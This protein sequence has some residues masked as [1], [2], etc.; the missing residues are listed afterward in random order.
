MGWRMMSLTHGL[1]QP[2]APSDRVGDT[3]VAV[4]AVFGCLSIVLA[5]YLLSWTVRSSA[6]PWLDG[7]LIDGFEVIAAALCLAR[8]VR[9]GPGRAV[10]LTLG[11]AVLSW[12]IGDLVL[13]AESI[14]GNL[15]PTP[16]WADFF[17]VGFYPLAYVGVAGFLC[18]QVRRLSTPNWLD[19]AVAAAGAAAVCAAFEFHR[20]LHATGGHRAA[21]VTA[22][23]YPIGDLLLFSLVAGGSAVMSGQRKAPWILI[24]TAMAVNVAGDTANLFSAS[25]PMHLDAA[26]DATS[27][28]TS[29]LLL[30]M[31]VWCRP[32]PSNPL[33]TQ[34]PAG[35]VI[36]GICGG[37]AL[38]VL[39]V[40]NLDAMSRA[41]VYLATATLLLVG[42]RLVLSMRAMR[43][44]SQERRRQSVTDELTGL[45]NRRH[46]LAVL[47]A[48][49]A[50]TA[51]TVEPRSLAFLFVDLDHFKEIND[52][53]GH[54]A[55]DT[56]LQHV[57]D[58]L[59][60]CMRETDLLVRLGG[61]EFVVLLVDSDA[62]YATTV[63]Q[64]VTASLTEPMVIDAVR[65]RIG[66]SI[67][68]AFAPDDATNSAG[69]LW[70]ADVAM[71]RA[72]STG[73]PYAL[74]NKDVDKGADHL[75]L[76]EDL[77]AAIEKHEL[78]LHY[79]PQLDLRTHEV[80]AVECLLRWA[81]PQRGLIPPLEFLPLAEEAGIM[82]TITSLVLADALAQCAAWRRASHPL[83]VAINVSTTDLLD[84]HFVDRV[85]ELLRRNDVPADAV[86]LEITETI[87]ISD[88]ERSERVIR[89]LRDLGVV[90]SIDD[91]GAGLTSGRASTSAGHYPQTKSCSDSD[92]HSRVIRARGVVEAALAAE[93]ATAA[94]K[95]TESSLPK[96]VGNITDPQS[97]LMPT[98]KGFL[99]GYNAQFAVTADQ[100]IIAE[101]LGQ[102][103]ND[104]ASFVPMLHAKTSRSEHR[105]GV[106]L[107]DACY[108]SD[109]NLAAPG[110]DRLIAL[111][112]GR[113]QAK[114]AQHEP[115]TRPPPHG[116]TPR[117]AMD[118]R[119]RTA[120][121][122]ALHKRR[123]AT[124]EPGIGNLKKIL[125]R[126]S[127]RGL[128]N[129]L[130]ELHLAASAFN[131]M[132]IHRATAI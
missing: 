35:F 99:Q 50:E 41:A 114:A 42:V 116:A 120:E 34:R 110:P 48:F 23:V 13:G 83:T 78:I 58:R 32:R 131:L 86:V 37:S 16:S 69:L 1:S 19:G 27:W 26:L 91:F 40:G 31:S 77:E 18:G 123:G 12:A 84:A 60:A 88:F 107:A 72:K 53:F 6:S 90:V 92:Q 81:H 130:S 128:E 59:S 65:A 95:P 55:G 85:G 80:V 94:S 108:G 62:G 98:R 124:V 14:G 75:Q 112:K 66:A 76:L 61:D 105:L 52:A 10:A 127:C 102:N 51:A 87:V 118:H 100:I 132:K 2:A 21:T 3:P 121:G 28:P 8:G 22:L 104:M 70:C 125:D 25:W 79:Q 9:R 119:L 49:F 126:F 97:R 43:S 39:V 117:Q 11:L 63:A 57:A 15:V 54:S 45:G 17:Y 33:T 122:S 73:T 68:V 47:D 29:I 20:I 30:S 74:Y 89:Q 36:P 67:G 109:R 113:N 46:L 129:A 103:T 44:L 38:L 111:N 5:V 71:Y 56:L 115:A 101:Q 82:G 64:R 96:T 93:Q 4:R 106:I 7:W 24:A